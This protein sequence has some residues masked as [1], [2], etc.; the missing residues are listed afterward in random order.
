MNQKAKLTNKIA[1]FFNNKRFK[2]G[3][4]SVVFTA[5]FITG[6][7]LI[8]IIVGLILERFD[9]TLDFTSGQMFSI[10]ENTVRFLE[11]ITDNVTITV[12]STENDFKSGSG[13][14]NTGEYYNQTNEILKRFAGTNRNISLK[15]T[16]LMTNPDFAKKYDRLSVGSIIVQSANTGRHKILDANDYFNI[17]YY[18]LSSGNTISGE[19]VQM[20]YTFGMSDYVYADIS[21]GAE[22]AF[23][24]AILSVTD[25]SPVHVGFMTGHGEQKNER[26]NFLLEMNSYSIQTLDLITGD[27]PPE[28]DFI[29]A[30]SP[31]ADYG[32]DTVSKLAEWL[33]NG[34]AFGKSIMYIAHQSAETPNI[35]AFLEEWGIGIERTY[36]MQSDT[37][38]TAPVAG[39]DFPIQYYKPD[40]FG[41]G[42]N[43]DYK[44]FGELLRYTY[45]IYEAW[46]NVETVSILSAHDGAVLVTFEDFDEGG[47]KPEETD[48][49]S[50]GIM[51]SKIRFE[52][53]DV[54]SSRVIAFGGSYIFNP[55]FMEMRNANNAEYFINMI[56]EVNGKNI[57]RE[58]II[59]IA[60]K[61]F[62]VAMFQI[63][64]K[65]SKTIGFIFALLLPC[66][67]IFIGIF[68][69]VKRR[70]V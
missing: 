22:S 69:W 58:E 68:V 26:M 55:G 41:E 44:I 24:S 53:L 27:I 42:L 29:I 65:Q 10:G 60:P 5:A 12:C 13:S 64:A 8:N 36:V 61:S 50:V 21:A 49:Y 18:D 59:T 52:E 3:S 70:R 54:I 14:A 17:T 28:V 57:Q 4:L 30:D 46:Q 62:S 33:D 66:I 38:Y 63:T 51:S 47:E 32:I 11:G 56:N 31:N 40:K 20:Y 19:E 16:D 1:G 34:G 67:I 15:Y 23:L 2:Y 45:R 25:T 6:V 43:P 37:R 48:A 7:I 39:I 35:D 9:T